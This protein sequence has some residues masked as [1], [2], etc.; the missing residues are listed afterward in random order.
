MIGRYKNKKPKKPPTTNTDHDF[1][2]MEVQPDPPCLSNLVFLFFGFSASF[3][4]PFLSN[5]GSFVFWAFLQWLGE[6]TKGSIHDPYN[7]PLIAY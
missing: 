5:L 1:K 7:D 6:L 4:P 3:G 2:R